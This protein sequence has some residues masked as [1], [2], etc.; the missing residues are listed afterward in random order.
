MCRYCEL[1]TD[2]I[3]YL[4]FPL[5]TLNKKMLY[6]R[7]S[8]SHV[9]YRIS[10]K[11]CDIDRK[12][13]TMTLLA[14]STMTRYIWR[15]KNLARLFSSTIQK[16]KTNQQTSQMKLACPNLARHWRYC[17]MRGI[18]TY[19]YCRFS[20]VGNW[21]LVKLIAG[22]KFWRSHVCLRSQAGNSVP[23]TGSMTASG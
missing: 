18:L 3:H 15:A 16:R 1:W 12:P 5:L 19:I 20:N 13:S 9:F 4:L 22:T 10:K 23:I 6:G 17:H 2:F 21:E 7:S 8:C 14:L 11:F